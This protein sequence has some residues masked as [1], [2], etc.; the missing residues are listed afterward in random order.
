[1]TKRLAGL[2]F[3]LAIG[4]ACS[5]GSAPQGTLA[6]DGATSAERQNATVDTSSTTSMRTVGRS[7]GVGDHAVPAKSRFREVTVPAGTT[8]NLELE[9]AVS[10]DKSRS[11]DPVRASLSAPIRVD[12]MT[13]VPAGSEA[14]GSVL[15]ARRSGRV[16]GRASV[17]FWFDRLRSG[18]ESYAIR[19]A[20]IAREAKPTKGEDAK[21]IGFGAGAGAVIGAI[22]G[23]KKG[24]AIGAA[25]GGGAGSGVVLAT[26][27]QEV[28]LGRGLRLKTTL[29]EPL[30]VQVS[31]D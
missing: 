15:E 6:R 10:S 12:G 20:R 28:R 25:V 5:S 27:G 26:R 19:T 31:F 14:T 22:A 18:D 30:T 11:E 21:K 29:E 17:A 13:V 8:L 23:G 4:A 9:T 7:S 3:G 16:S 24:A 2:V 1:M